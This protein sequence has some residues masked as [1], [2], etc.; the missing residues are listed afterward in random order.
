MRPA[1]INFITS[2]CFGIFV[3]R[4]PAFIYNPAIELQPEMKLH[5]YLRFSTRQGQDLFIC[6][7]IPELGYQ[8]KLTTQPV[9]MKYKNQDF[10]EIIVELASLPP[11]PVMYYYQLKMEDGSI[12]H[13]WGNDRKFKFLQNMMICRFSIPGT[14][15][16][17]MK[18]H[19]ILLPFRKSSANAIK[20]IRKKNSQNIYPYI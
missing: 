11:D 12:V 3:A 14:M 19:F 4:M 5:F 13:E 8:N 10:W 7:N 15:Q 2:S 1:D 6:G 18:M 20:K 9:L 16:V 17:N